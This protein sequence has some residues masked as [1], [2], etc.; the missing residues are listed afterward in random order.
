MEY[1]DVKI[2]K[3]DTLNKFVTTEKYIKYKDI[4]KVINKLYPDNKF[5]LI[6]FSKRF[7]TCY[8]N[9]ITDDNKRVILC[10]YVKGNV[11]DVIVISKLTGRYREST[12]GRYIVYEPD[13]LTKLEFHLY[14]YQIYKH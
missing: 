14:E 5:F 11:K 3:N 1:L 7:R 13:Y 8:I 2:I 6:N 9:F 4:T 10:G 12:D